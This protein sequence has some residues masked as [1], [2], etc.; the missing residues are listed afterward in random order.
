MEPLEF[1]HG[2]EISD[3]VSARLKSLSDSHSILTVGHITKFVEPINGT[4][5]LAD[6]LETLSVRQDINSLPVEGD[7]G[8]AGLVHK[9]DLLKKKSAFSNP[10]V[11]KL[12]DRSP[13]YLA[14]EENC[15][16]AMETVL[17]REPER[18]YD[19]FMIY[20]RGRFFGVGTFVDLSRNMAAIRA[21]E[22]AHARE[23]QEFLIG[24]NSA[25]RPGL[26]VSTYVRMAHEIGGDYLQCME[27]GGALSLLSTFDVSGKGTAAAL[28]TS[29]ISS[30]FSTLKASGSLG[31]RAP[32][33]LVSLLNSVVMDQTPEEMFVAAV[34]MFVDR[35]KHEVSLFNCGYSPVYLFFADQG[36]VKGKII[37]PNLWPLGIKEFVDPKSY[38][39]PSVGN[40]RLFVH[41]DGLTDA[42]NERGER[43]DEERF[44]KFLYPR[45]MK[46]VDGILAEL[47]KEIREFTGSAPPVDDI[48][49]LAAEFS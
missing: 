7:R 25:D 43:Y 38:T 28:L 47:D 1:L 6:A 40:L 49:V 33:S 26:S 15:E 20:K 44:R 30:F 42:C 36:K 2:T 39:V 13:F 48:T 23:M 19:D 3:F 37:N 24:R 22:L 35:E 14:A 12:L 16:K 27:L 34:F 8:V 18:I 45:C 31:S 41:S 17:A 32:G 4:V 5:A 11:E 10:P 9:R 29:T 46:P 21:M